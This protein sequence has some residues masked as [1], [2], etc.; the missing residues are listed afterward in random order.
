VRA[1]LHLLKLAI[2][3]A[4]AATLPLLLATVVAACTNGNGFPH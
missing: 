2:G 3:T 4:V 1:R